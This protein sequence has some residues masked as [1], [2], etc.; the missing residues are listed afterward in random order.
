MLMAQAALM[1]NESRGVH[2]RG[3]FPERDDANFAKHIEQAREQI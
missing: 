1:R 2:Y 3:D